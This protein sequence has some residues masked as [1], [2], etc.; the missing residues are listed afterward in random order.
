VSHKRKIV[1]FTSDDF[2]ACIIAVFCGL[3]TWTVFVVGLVYCAVLAVFAPKTKSPRTI[4]PGFTFLFAFATAAAAC[5]SA[6]GLLFA[7]E[8]V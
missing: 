1:T 7:A 4:V 5:L 3:V 2:V 6:A 8:E